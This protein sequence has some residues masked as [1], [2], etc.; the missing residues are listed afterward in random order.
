MQKY[1][2]EMSTTFM[3]ERLCS[4]LIYFCTRSRWKFTFFRLLWNVSL[5]ITNIFFSAEKIILKWKIGFENCVVK[6]HL[7]IMINSTYNVSR[8]PIHLVCGT[9]LCGKCVLH[10]CATCVWHT[11]LCNMW[12]TIRVCCYSSCSCDLWMSP[13]LQYLGS[14]S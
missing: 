3:L 9:C 14:P 6:E 1:H 13:H 10:V 2:C 4:E 5:W 8:D 7:E 11:C 12:L